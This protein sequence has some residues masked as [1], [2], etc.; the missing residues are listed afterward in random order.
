MGVDSGHLKYMVSE[1]T[2]N[3]HAVVTG[4][5]SHAVTTARTLLPNHSIK[6]KFTLARKTLPQKAKLS[7]KKF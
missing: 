3:T 2:I 5:P 6:K 4:A 7:H 1:E